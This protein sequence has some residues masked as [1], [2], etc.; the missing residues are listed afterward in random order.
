M[1]QIVISSTT[2]SSAWDDDNSVTINTAWSA[3]SANTWAYVS[4]DMSLVG[5]NGGTWLGAGLGDA[6]IP[7]LNRSGNAAFGL[8]KSSGSFPMGNA[9]SSIPLG[10]QGIVMGGPADG[11]SWTLTAN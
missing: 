2:D 5:G 1:A 8:S 3:F 10:T 7:F 9:F 11:D 6:T 4:G